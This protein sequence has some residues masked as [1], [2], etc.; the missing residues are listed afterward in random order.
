MVRP[1][2]ERKDREYFSL[3]T[4]RAFIL[5][6]FLAVFMVGS[7]GYSS[8]PILGAWALEAFFLFGG[9][10]ITTWWLLFFFD[11]FDTALSLRAAMTS[12]VIALP[13]VVVL[14]LL[15][16]VVYAGQMKFMNALISLLAVHAFGYG[17]LF[18][19]FVVLLAISIVVRLLLHSIV[20]SFYINFK[21]SY[22]TLF[23][24]A[25]Q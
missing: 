13:L 10:V 17:A 24:S 5:I 15:H 21:H 1:S 18:F 11:T 20:T 14:S 23:F 16:S 3:Y 22:H 8:L 25:E 12:W 6:A 7:A 4:R 9:F 2:I 19:C